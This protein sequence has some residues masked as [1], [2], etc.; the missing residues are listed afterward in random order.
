M[1]Y[2]E[3]NLIELLQKN[4]GIVVNV[5]DNSIEPYNLTIDENDFGMCFYVPVEKLDDNVLQALN[6]FNKDVYVLNFIDF[7]MGVIKNEK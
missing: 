4:I 2:T 5:R 6:Q 7:Y 3:K 1:K